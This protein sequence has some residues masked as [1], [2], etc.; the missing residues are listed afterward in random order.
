MR[1]LRAKGNFIDDGLGL[2]LEDMKAL[3]DVEESEVKNDKE[4]A[5]DAA[6]ERLSKIAEEYVVHKETLKEAMKKAE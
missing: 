3:F 6:Y 5:T 1:G 2:D 4:K